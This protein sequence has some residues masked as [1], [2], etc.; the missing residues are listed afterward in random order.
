MNKEKIKAKKKRWY[1]MNKE[2]AKA[3][4]REYYQANKE[5]MLSA[6]KKRRS[7]ANYANGIIYVINN[8]IDKRQ[9]VGCTAL[10]VTERWKEH[11]KAGR[12]EKNGDWSEMYRTMK[13]LGQ[14]HFSI[15][16]YKKYPCSSRQELEKE[17]ARVIKRMTDKGIKL[18]NIEQEAGTRS[19]ATKSKVRAGL[20]KRGCLRE[21]CDGRWTYTWTPSAGVSRTVNFS[22]KKYG[23]KQAKAMAKAKQDEIYPNEI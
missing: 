21:T 7:Q 2:K 23:P 5:R 13:D 11:L 1:E 20:L 18:F 10:N 22:I 4:A 8:D 9:Y 3:Q 15:T 16:V 19:Q 14:D 12:S 6:C 17:E